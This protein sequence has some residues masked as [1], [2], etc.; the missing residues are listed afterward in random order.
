VSFKPVKGK[1]EKGGEERYDFPIALGMY[2]H[3]ALEVE[4]DGLGKIKL[5]TLHP[6][7]QQ[8]GLDPWKYYKEVRDGINVQALF[9]FNRYR[10]EQHL[11]ILLDR[12]LYTAMSVYLRYYM[13]TTKKIVC[14]NWD[15]LVSVIRKLI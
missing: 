7:I 12:R 11:M 10:D 4:Y 15:E 9:R 6:I 8:M 1:I 2:Q 3:G 13:D 14:R 5:P